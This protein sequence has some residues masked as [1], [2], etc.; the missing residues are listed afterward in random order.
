MALG[1]FQRRMA[2]STYA[3]LR[4]LER[5]LQKLDGVIADVMAGKIDLLKLAKQ[6]ERLREDD[7]PFD[8]HT[9]DEE[10]GGDGEEEN[11]RS[12]EE[13]LGSFV[14]T[15]IA[16]LEIEKEY[17]SNLLTLARKV[18]SLGH[19]SKFER[20]RGIIEDKRFRNEKLLV[21]T[22]HRDTMIY[23]KAVLT[24]LVYRSGGEHSRW[25]E[26]RRTW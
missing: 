14:A 16:D 15:T 26:L 12:E 4:S 8:A 5:R 3:L 25:H 20:L 7:D 2:S 13:I 9:A 6:A 11:E 17:V 23:L 21:F 24:V 18:Q 10:A 22:E 19:E 1:V